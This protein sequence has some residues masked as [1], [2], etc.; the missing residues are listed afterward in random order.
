MF[1]LSRVQTH[2]V[3]TG[4]RGPRYKD[5][6]VL[7]PVSSVRLWQGKLRMSSW[8]GV[9]PHRALWYLAS[10]T[11]QGPCLGGACRSLGLCQEELLAVVL[12]PALFGC[13]SLLTCAR[14]SLWGQPGFLPHLSSSALILET[15]GTF[16]CLPCILS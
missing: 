1:T 6:Y 5:R 13:P 8:L 16:F 10:E 14:S 11:P 9:G 4:Q 15:N 3:R 12:A 2:A 7:N